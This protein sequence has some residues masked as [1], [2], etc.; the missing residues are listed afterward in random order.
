[1][2]RRIHSIEG[3][4]SE[5]QGFIQVVQQIKK[6]LSISFIFL[7][8]RTYFNVKRFLSIYNM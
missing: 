2:E 7:F 8:K 6:L 3:A 1:M 4:L 5:M